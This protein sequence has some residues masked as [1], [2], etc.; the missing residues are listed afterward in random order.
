MQSE[1]HETLY[2]RLAD[3]TDRTQFA[4]DQDDFQVLMGLLQEHRD[5]MGKINRAGLSRDTNLMKLIEELNKQVQEV[6]QEIAKRRKELGRQ[7]IM[8]EKKKKVSAAYAGAML[9]IMA[10]I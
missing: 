9:P 6:V 10:I 1:T 4:L 8:F 2:R 3:I 5:V 7:L